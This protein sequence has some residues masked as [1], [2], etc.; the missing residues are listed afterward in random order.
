MAFLFSQI[1]YFISDNEVEATSS[2]GQAT[3]MKGLLFYNNDF[4]KAESL[5][6][7]WTKD[8][9]PDT[10][11]ANNL[12]FAARQSLI[13]AKPDPRGSF[14]FCV[15]LEHLFGF[16]QDYRKVIY[17]VNHRIALTRQSDTDA[18]YRE[19]RSRLVRSH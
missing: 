13:V 6:L 14:A 12:G 18:I 15:P 1:R 11:L 19:E 10:V 5:G 17:G 8:T 9:S 4:A 16:C 7:C 3:T 2:P